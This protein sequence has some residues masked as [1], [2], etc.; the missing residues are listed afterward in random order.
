MRRKTLLLLLI[1]ATLGVLLPSVAHAFPSEEFHRRGKEVHD[2][3]GIARTRAALSDGFLGLS[4]TGFDPIIARESMGANADVAWRLGEEFARKYPD[5]NQRAEQ[6]FYFVRNRVVYTSDKDQF[7]RGEFARN[8]DEMAAAIAKNEK[9][10][11]D[12]EDSAVLLAVLYKAAG[13]RSALVLTPGHVAALVY[14]PEYRKARKL[15]VEG[16]GGWVWAEATG[17]TNPFGWLPE[18]LRAGEKR[19]SEVLAGELKKQEPGPGRYKSGTLGRRRPRGRLGPG[20][21]RSAGGR[22]LHVGDDRRQGR[23]R[24]PKKKTV[25]SGGRSPSPWPSPIEGEG[26]C[27]PPPRHLR[28]IDD[29]RLPQLRHFLGIHPQ[30][31][32]KHVGVMLAQQRRG[33]THPS[34]GPAQPPL[35]AVDGLSSQGRVVH[36]NE[37]AALAMQG[38]IR[39]LRDLQAGQGCH[40]GLL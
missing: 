30:Q 26:I 21:L 8:A 34:G 13:Y 20:T 29:L 24:P 12:C 6:I 18:S 5:R 33:A 16:E 27:R 10:A 15:S 32:A 28:L 9:T 36:L 38:V 40:A 14:L 23:R 2:D 31:A 7:G 4:R 22:G 19:T 35:D 11:G 3:W 1:T 37:G 25:K 39:H 17:A